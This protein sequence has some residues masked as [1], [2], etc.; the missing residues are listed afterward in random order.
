M[1]SNDMFPIIPHQTFTEPSLENVHSSE[2][3]IFWWKLRDCWRIQLQNSNLYL[4]SS[5]VNAWWRDILYGCC[6]FSWKIRQIE[7]RLIPESLSVRLNEWQGCNWA[8]ARISGILLF[9]TWRRIRLLVLWSG[10]IISLLVI[11]L[12]KREKTLYEWGARSGY[13]SRHNLAAALNWPSHSPKISIISQASAFEYDMA[14]K[15]EFCYTLLDRHEKRIWQDKTFLIDSRLRLFWMNFCGCS[16]VRNA[17]GE[18]FRYYWQ[19]YWT[20]RN[21]RK[22]MCMCTCVRRKTKLT[23]VKYS[24]L[25]LINAARK[26]GH[27][28]RNLLSF[29][30]CLKIFFYNCA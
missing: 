28:R 17:R 8:D 30:H 16:Y 19:N 20:K 27:F 9:L 12:A 1:R 22:R 10:W 5:I 25:G 7:L 6:L 21:E 14:G 23:G 29:R 24:V 2:N 18:F 11:R 3:K 15:W 13:R 26:I 4:K